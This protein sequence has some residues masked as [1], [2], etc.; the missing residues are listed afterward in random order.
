VKDWLEWQF[1]EYGLEMTM[2]LNEPEVDEDVYWMCTEDTDNWCEV[3]LDDPEKTDEELEICYKETKLTED[4]GGYA[5]FVAFANQ[6]TIAEEYLTD[7]ESAIDAEI[8][9]YGITR[10]KDMTEDEL[11]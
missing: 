4:C 10:I 7:I 8:D 2:N 6:N 9:K 11:D 5:W 3:A 1:E